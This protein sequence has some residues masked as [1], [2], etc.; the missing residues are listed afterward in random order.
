MLERRF[1][2]HLFCDENVFNIATCCDDL[3]ISLS[4]LGAQ[5]TQAEPLLC[6]HARS[7]I[8][9]LVLKSARDRVRPRAITERKRCEQIDLCEIFGKFSALFFFWR[10]LCIL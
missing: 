1:I 2:M 6:A 10:R 9:L 3:S 5:G 8:D 7:L 4:Y